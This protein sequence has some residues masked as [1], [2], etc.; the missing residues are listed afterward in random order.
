MQPRHK[1]SDQSRV[2]VCLVSSLVYSNNVALVI[3]LKTGLVRPQFHVK[4]DAQ[5]QTETGVNILSPRGGI[6]LSAN[7][8]PMKR[9]AGNNNHPESMIKKLKQYESSQKDTEPGIQNWG[10]TRGDRQHQ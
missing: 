9:N 5:F 1:C 10:K 4:L 8:T 3:S 6:P 2:G 7:R